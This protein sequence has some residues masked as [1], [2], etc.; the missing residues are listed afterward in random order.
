MKYGL[1]T[2]KETENIGDDIQSYVAIKFLPRIDYYIEREKLD[3]FV[4]NKK[5]QVL[6]IMNGWFL[7]SKINFPLSPYIYPIY[8]STHFSTYNSG[9]ITDEYLNDY[10]KKHLDKYAPIGCRD[11]GTM[12]LLNKKNIKNYFSGCLTLTI[13]KDSKVKKKDYICIVD[14]DEQ[15]EKY[16]YENFADTT[17]IIKKT[18]RLNKDKNKILS[19]EERFKNVKQLLDVYQGAKLVITSRLHC[20]LPCLALGTPVLLLYDEDKEY[21]KDRLSDYAKLVNSLSTK[22]F[23]K[24][25]KEKIN[26]HIENPKQYMKIRRNITKKVQELIENGKISIEKDKKTLPEIKHYK[27]GFVEYKENIDYLYKTAVER[28]YIDKRNYINMLN[29][30]DYWKKE[31]YILLEE[32]N[33]ER[34]S[35]Y[36]K[37]VNNILKKYEEICLENKILKEKTKKQ[38]KKGKKYE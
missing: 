5:E 17:K 34:V 8:I 9:G 12:N 26:S 6:T 37:E 22:E 28:M 29:E 30:R 7:H 32:S 13:E 25:G 24:S 4:P 1:I 2:F 35:N 11:T 15:A 38:E 3:L 20:A 31:W 19:W 21:T 27:E 33:P 23:L 14:I 10:S 18:H 16:I 36:K